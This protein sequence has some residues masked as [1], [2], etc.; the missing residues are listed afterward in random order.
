MLQGDVC[1]YRAISIVAILM[2]VVSVAQGVCIRYAKSGSVPR[3][4]CGKFIADGGSSMTEELAS[5]V[6]AWLAQTGYPLEM[7]VAQR[8]SSAQLARDWELAPN[9]IYVDP[10]TKDERETD[11]SLEWWQ[12]EDAFML[13]YRI[14]MECKNTAQPWVVF[15][16]AG[17]AGQSASIFKSYP[18]LTYYW[19]SSL[20]QLRGLLDSLDKYLAGRVHS[21]P[22]SGYAIVEAFKQSNGKDV[23]HNSV[24]QALSAAVGA[25]RLPIWDNAEDKV[26]GSATVAP[27]VITTSPLFEARLDSNGRSVVVSPVTSS[28]VDV[29][30]KGIYPDVRVL[31]VNEQ[32]LDEIVDDCRALQEHLPEFCK[33]FNVGSIDMS[34]TVYSMRGAPNFS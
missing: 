26:P 4:V 19:E 18:N 16:R 24:R 25:M 5:K 21:W 31:V 30:F 33:I 10:I 1:V 13:S 32:H 27:I 20:G 9:A 2:A 29:R 11:Y 7:R 14:V 8:L 6:S 34:K 28:A 15:R 23:A 3:D 17:A 22:S 12:G